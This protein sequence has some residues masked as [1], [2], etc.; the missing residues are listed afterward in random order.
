[1][2]YQLATAKVWDGSEWVQAVGESWFSQFDD[3]TPVDAATATITADVTAHTK[4]AYTEIVAST[5]AETSA[6]WFRFFGVGTA[7]TNTATLLDIAVGA[8]GSETIVIP[9]VGIGSAAT[10]NRN[11]VCV[12]VPLRV[13]A[14]TRISARIQSVV[15]GG[16]TGS[17]EMRTFAWGNPALSPT[18]LD[19]FGSDTATS[20]ALVFASAGAYTQVAASTTKAYKAFVMVPSAHN[21]QLD[22]TT[23]VITLAT[24]AAASETPI[25][26]TSGRTAAS[27]EVDTAVFPIVPTSADVPTGSRLAVLN[28]G[29]SGS[30]AGTTT[31]Y[32]VTVIGIPA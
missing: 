22:N 2:T 11:G 14:G 8:S 15:A 5:A 17:V 19:T 1:M 32:G 26:Q 3:T 28:T 13:A 31:R 29:L 23:V 21:I 12:L 4:G 16:K 10:P 9:N 6:V 30:G 24:G 18:A 27:E 25:G 20:Q 7:S